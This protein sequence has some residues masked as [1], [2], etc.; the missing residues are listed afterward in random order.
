MF[1]RSNSEHSKNEN[2]VYLYPKSSCNCY[3]CL[4]KSKSTDWSGTPTNLSIPNCK[5]PEI[6]ECAYRDNLRISNQPSKGDEITTY[7]DIF[8]NITPINPQNYIDKYSTSFDKVNCEKCQG[9]KSNCHCPNPTFASWDPRLLNTMRAQ[10]LTLDR[11]PLNSTPKLSTIYN[12]E[13]RGYGQNYKTYSDINAG[14]IMY[15]WDKERQNAYYKPLFDQESPVMKTIYKDPMGAIKPEYRRL[16][17]Q[18]NE[19]T[20]QGC[21]YSPYGLSSIYDS[22]TFRNDILARQMTK[23]NQERWMPRYSESGTEI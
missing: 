9:D 21:D 20:F 6:L 8:K 11:P 2:R 1:E 10:Y 18:R 4:A 19:A 7:N 14:T 16:R 5:I 3:H 12:E 13:Y 15:Y 22:Q 23:I 17:E